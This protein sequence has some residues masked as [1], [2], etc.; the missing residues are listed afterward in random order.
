MAD[1]VGTVCNV[2]D[3]LSVGEAEIY[4]SN[5]F[6][7]MERRFSLDGNRKYIIPCF[8][9]EIRWEQENMIEL[10]KDI[11]R[12]SCF[13]G[14]IILTNTKQREYEI[15]D[16]QQRLTALLMITKYLHFKYKNIFIT[17]FKFCEIENQ[18]FDKF[19]L[20]VNNDFDEEKLS[21][22]EKRAIE[23]SDIYKQKKQYIEL[24]NSIETSGIIKEEDVSSFWD[25]LRECKLN[26][27]VN[28]EKDSKKSIR[29]FLD[30]NVKGVKLDKEDIFKAYLFS[31]NPSNDFGEDIF[32]KWKGLKKAS[33]ELNSLKGQIYPLMLMILHFFYCD[34]YKENP[35]RYV[36]LSFNENFT[37]CKKL[38][39]SEGVE[40]QKG[41]HI[42][43]VINNNRYMLSA[44]EKLTTFSEYMVQTI[45]YDQPTFQEKEILS[46]K[47]GLDSEEIVIIFN[48]IKKIMLDRLSMPKVLVMK[49]MLDVV[50]NPTA[51]KNDYRKIY[52]V[53][54][55]SIL[56]V[57]FDGKKTSDELYKIVK[58]DNWY[59]ELIEQIVGYLSPC[60]LNERQ[61][62]A[63]YKYAIK[64]DE[65]TEQFR[66]KSLATIYNYMEFRKDD[67]TGEV[68]VGVKKKKLSELK[69]FLTNDKRFS[70]EHFVINDKKKFT[71]SLS[72][73]SI[74]EKYP[75]TI[76]RNSLSLFNFIFIPKVHNQNMS[77]MLLADKFSYIQKNDVKI[78]CEYSKMVYEIYSNHMAE[79]PCISET[80]TEEEARKIVKEYYENDFKDL[81]IQSVNEILLQVQKRFMNM[82]KEYN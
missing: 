57:L 71:I 53:Y 22:D 24:W 61:I 17:P 8:Q 75:G 38:E 36:L 58:Q 6:T 2:E 78:E 31:K 59:D 12:G 33:I 55:L 35:K 10:L 26:V 54:L 65:G 74:T 51:T 76:G 47:I 45:K 80:S 60:N 1:I 28:I 16:G 20:L 40:Y 25:K 49:Y 62:D 70:I 56:F 73:K 29:Y 44:L 11:N 23:E 30:V 67:A 64:K 82:L 14:N 77:N 39:I 15:L 13:L 69:E 18:S 48:F 32:D 4:I 5:A 19:M 43:N 21:E 37:L 81:Y 66:C 68:Y 63:Q 41:E 52:G 46:K 72:K 34:L 79:Y 3:F 7:D 50:F 42:I 27:I 9:R